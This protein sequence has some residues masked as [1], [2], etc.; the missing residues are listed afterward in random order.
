MTVTARGAEERSPE[1]RFAAAFTAHYAAIGAVFREFARLAE[2]AKLSEAVGFC[3]G[4]RAA[5]TKAVGEV[6]GRAEVRAALTRLAAS[7]PHIPY[8][9]L[10]HNQSFVWD[11]QSQLRQMF[12]GADVSWGDVESMLYFRTVSDS[13]VRAC[14][15]PA[16][17]RVR[18]SLQARA[19]RISA[20]LGPPADGDA[21]PRP[22]LPAILQ[23]GGVPAR[24]IGVVKLDPKHVEVPLRVRSLPVVPAAGLTTEAGIEGL[25][26]SFWSRVRAGPPLLAPADIAISICE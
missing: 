21:P 4:I 3:A 14:A 8:G 12:E 10:A 17:R 9:A 23:L 11:I 13:L 22:P 20:V 2:L 19:D 7:A 15:A 24:A 6:D 16:E 26:G 1:A 5:L 25:T 18:A